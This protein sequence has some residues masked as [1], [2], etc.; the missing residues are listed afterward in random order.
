[1]LSRHINYLIDPLAF[2][3]KQSE[4]VGIYRC[5]KMRE[6][7]SQ[8]VVGKDAVELEK[9][10]FVQYIAPFISTVTKL[11]KFKMFLLQSK[12]VLQKI[13]LRYYFPQSYPP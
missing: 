12:A 6:L 4:N 3:L 11:Q 7:R 2:G 13:V 5:L 9:Y 1:M 10:F 8:S